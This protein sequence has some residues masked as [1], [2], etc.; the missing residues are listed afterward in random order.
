MQV[1]TATGEMF[2]K[3]ANA[4]FMETSAKDGHNVQELFKEIGKFYFNTV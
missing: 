1:S 3:N 4:I 2:A